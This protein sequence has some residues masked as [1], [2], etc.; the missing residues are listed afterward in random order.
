V[1]VTGLLISKLKYTGNPTVHS[2][3]AD[4]I[5]TATPDGVFVGGTPMFVPNT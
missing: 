2:V 3:V 5:N 4:C 1:G